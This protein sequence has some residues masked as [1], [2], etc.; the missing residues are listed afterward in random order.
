[1]NEK[2]LFL[3]IIK[4]SDVS[5]IFE[6]VGE[7]SKSKNSA[8]RKQRLK[9][10]LS[11]TT[12]GMGP[13]KRP[14]WDWL[15]DEFSLPEYEDLTINQMLKQ[16]VVN[17]PY[18]P[19]S[20]RFFTLKRYQP[21]F[22]ENHLEQMSQNVSDNVYFLNNLIQFETDEEVESFWEHYISFTAKTGGLR[23]LI[24]NMYNWVE[25]HL[26]GEPEEWIPLAK[27]LSLK[28]FEEALPKEDNLEFRTFVALVTFLKFSEVSN[29]L[30]MKIFFALQFDYGQ[31][32]QAYLKKIFSDAEE[33]LVS[34]RQELQQ[35]QKE[36]RKEIRSLEQQL[37]QKERDLERAKAK[38]STEAQ[39]VAET[40]RQLRVKYEKEN[41][42]LT[43][44][45]EKLR[46]TVLKQ[47]QLTDFF[48]R[49][50]TQ[51]YP[52]LKWVI[53]HTFPLMFAKEIF[54]E[55]EFVELKEIQKIDFKEVDALWISQSGT[56]YAEKRNLSLLAQKHQ[57]K[58]TEI[59]AK[60]ERELIM[61]LSVAIKEYEQ[62]KMNRLVK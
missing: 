18:I 37:K 32:I 36:M 2:D 27:T 14:L 13:Q 44:E 9:K 8:Y 19:L 5:A 33:A 40:T 28:E 50:L 60:E 45:V 31:V 62:L 56:S 55:F 3:S 4:D 59:Q 23:F 52:N 20:I 61:E 54:P 15:C 58:L 7:K 11:T 38:S 16:F 17:E 22:F 34:E 25:T 42:Q 30:K 26:E 6:M 1:M 35:R 10:M 53:A 41:H 48:K 49:G 29:E 21:E 57:L 12:G 51:K 39:E 47:E 43:T 24:D 46:E